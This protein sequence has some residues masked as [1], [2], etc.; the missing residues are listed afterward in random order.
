[1]LLE[2]VQWL[3]KVG[4]NL[5]EYVPV[6]GGV[7]HFMKEHAVHRKDMGFSTRKLSEE[8]RSVRIGGLD[9][10]GVFGVGVYGDGW[11][12]CASPVNPTTWIKMLCEK[13]PGAS[14]LL[15]PAARTPSADPNLERNRARRLSDPSP[16]FGGGGATS[17]LAGGADATRSIVHKPTTISTAAASAPSKPQ[18]TA[19]KAAA[20]K[21][22]KPSKPSTTSSKPSSKPSATSAANA[23][24]PA[25]PAGAATSSLPGPLPLAYPATS[26]PSTTKTITLDP[27]V[28]G[29]PQ[30][31][32]AYAADAP[33]PPQLHR[34]PSFSARSHWQAGYMPLD[35][36]LTLL[37]SHHSTDAARG[38]SAPPTICNPCSTALDGIR[39]CIRPF[40]RM[41]TDCLLP[42]LQGLGMMLY[43]ALWAGA[44]GKPSVGCGVVWILLLSTVV[45]FLTDWVY[46]ASG[47]V[48]VFFEVRP[49]HRDPHPRDTT[50]PLMPRHTHL[51]GGHVSRWRVI[52][53]WGTSVCAP[54]ARPAA[55]GRLPSQSEQRRSDCDPSRMGRWLHSRRGEP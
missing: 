31:P 46:A 26:Y 29:L 39:T 22:S 47:D 18:A 21:S 28:E 34:P 9:H 3:E 52:W 24:L 33:M 8:L 50:P 36:D 20:S 5:T 35:D 55:W 32:L 17:S 40:T 53:T 48:S 54:P 1:M 23:P 14:K 7:E 15:K 37:R 30:L 12:V 13:R 41:F 42:M 44:P 25:Y 10:E 6:L 43:A 45:W 51:T 2:K 38:S 27:N 4:G 16:G 11:K 49:R 19:S